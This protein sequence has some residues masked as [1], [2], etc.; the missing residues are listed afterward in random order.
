MRFV[1]LAGNFNRAW[2]I[3]A[4]HGRRKS[5]L[6]FG[7]CAALTFCLEPVSRSDSASPPVPQSYFGL[8]IHHIGNTTPW[9]DVP[10]AEWRLWDAHVAWPNL[11]PRPGQWHFELL[12][13]YVTAAEEH[14]VNILLP[15]GLSP[16]WASARPNERSTYQAGNAAGPGRIEDWRNYVRTVARRYKGRI[17]DYEIWNEPNY[18]GFWT[19]STE[20]M[21]ALTRDAE[22]VIHE[23][24]PSAIIVSPSATTVAG[25]QW[26]SEFLA[27]GGGKYVDVIGYHLYVMPQPPEETLPLLNKVRQIMQEN[28]VQEKP[29]WNTEM[30][31]AFPKP[32]PSGELA[33]A[34]LVRTYLL[35][36]SRGV[37]R[38]YWYAWDN[39]GWVSIETTERD[40]K[41]LAPAGRA[42]ATVQTWMV[43]ARLTECSQDGAQAWTCKLS[44][45]GAT[46]WIV[47]NA[48][49]A[50]SYIPPAQWHA[51]F[52]VSLQGVSQAV[53]KSGFDAGPSPVLVT[54]ATR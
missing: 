1:E 22:K 11:E 35:C 32:F 41:T 29:L 23:I 6:L 36:W 8:H 13:S 47:W 30:G 42:Y 45:N 33:A 50:K 4:Q 27:G 37:Q 54:S 15:L 34:Y 24:D 25:E 26:L 18:K 20:E 14:G 19:G 53:T 3:K 46:Q 49:G 51:K 5:A 12:D 39:H 52:I 2:T 21:I 31:W 10:F 40:N 17:H 43:G 16:T 9:P 44:R 7:L 38:L 48:G 28:G